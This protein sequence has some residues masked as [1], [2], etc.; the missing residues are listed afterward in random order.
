[1]G[2]WGSLETYTVDQHARAPDLYLTPDDAY[3]LGGSEELEVTV[4]NEGGAPLE[5][6]GGR[7]DDPR[8]EVTADTTTVEPGA[9]T[10]LRVR[11]TD[12]GAP[13]DTSLCLVT[14]DGDEG[15]VSIP[16]RSSSDL[17]GEQALGQDAIDFELPLADG[18]GTWRL[19]DYR[20][21]AVFLV[22]FATW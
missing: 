8:F 21:D 14:N 1:V 3:L 11:F 12:D 7:L 19:S 18:S 17:E 16:L 22:F 13:V 4:S 15:A 5:L 10:T 2:D 9:S 6:R 20:D